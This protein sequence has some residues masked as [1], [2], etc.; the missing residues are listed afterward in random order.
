MFVMHVEARELWVTSFITTLTFE[1]GPLTEPETS[2]QQAPW[3]S[4]SHTT[5]LGQKIHTPT[6]GSAVMSWNQSSV[7]HT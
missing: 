2:D 1:T 4:C 6:P 3:P 7:P 5:E